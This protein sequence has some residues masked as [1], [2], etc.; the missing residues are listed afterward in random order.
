M[1]NLKPCDIDISSLPWLPLEATYAFPNQPAIYFAIDSENVIQY[2]GMSVNPRTRWKKHHRHDELHKIG[3]IKVC[4]LFVDH[5]ELLREIE[6]AL[7]QWFRP[8]LNV[9]G[10]SSIDVQQTEPRLSFE[11]FVELYPFLTREQI[12]KVAGCSIALVDR[13]FMVGKTRKKPS[14]E[15]KARFE[16]AHWFWSK[17]ASEP[18]FFQMLRQIRH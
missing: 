5:P 2:I 8:P 14:D 15:H 7:I 16:I 17:N 18:T 9:S 3:G 1:V 12:A 13:W 11:E 10:I 4:Y 6:S